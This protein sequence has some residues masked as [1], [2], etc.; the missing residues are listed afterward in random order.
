MKSLS[1]YGTRNITLLVLGTAIN[2]IGSGVYLPLSMLILREMSSLSIVAVGLTLTLAQVVAVV[3]MPFVGRALDRIGAKHVLA[4]SMLAQAMG[5]ALYPFLQDP[6]AFI[7]LTILIAVGNQTG[8]TAR[9]TVI[10]ILT[11]DHARDRLLALNRS[12]ANAGLGLGGLILVLFSTEGLTTYSL[13]CWVNG[14]T[15][16]FAASLSALLRID[17]AQHKMVPQRFLNTLRDLRYARFLGSTLCASLLYTALTV[18]IPLY[19]IEVLQQPPTVA[20]VLFI[21]NTLIASV[22]GVP[23]VAL[24]HRL[25]ISRVQ[26]AKLGISM[27][28]IGL[29]ALPIGR[30]I[31]EV[32]VFAFVVLATAIYSI[33]EV[34]HGPTSAALS[35]GMAAEGRRGE[36]QAQY[37][38]AM[39]M[40]AAI[41]PAVFTFLISFRPSIGALFAGACG[42]I[43]YMLMDRAMD[44]PDQS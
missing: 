1:Q 32:T 16:L 33:G 41:A 6:V 43:G 38:M 20:G 39:T 42:L 8:K 12:L 23:A 10:A 31:P 44:K 14:A 40:G 15:F 36:Y 5:F 7:V 22:G 29:V 3:I 37:Q 28:A 11:K 19:V 24:M 30:I 27:L 17:P 26:A 2:A 35:L 25:G 34:L 9:P 21:V 13:I 18:F 4:W